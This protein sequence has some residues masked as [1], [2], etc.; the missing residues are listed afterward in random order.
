[1]SGLYVAAL[2]KGLHPEPP[3]DAT[4]R[5]E[6][7]RDWDAEG[8][9][10]MH[11]RLGAVDPATAA[12]LRP[13]DRQRVLRALEVGRAGGHPLAWWRDEARR[14]PVA[15]TWRTFEITCPVAELAKRIAQRARTMWAGGLL[16]ETRAI[17]ASGKRAELR[18]LAAIGYDEALDFLEG[19][20]TEEEAIA[21]M[22][23]RTRQLAKRQRT[24][25]R[26]QQQAVR[27]DGSGA[28]PTDETARF[29]ADSVRG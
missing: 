7:E 12:A 21:R 23:A 15:A 11:A 3:R 22:D 13:R 1:G 14:A 19:A 24:W 17:A 4:L 20:A 6:L 8:A 9:E 26:H 25:F 16:D 10:R 5:A 28:A 29:L 2:Q 27:V 18:R